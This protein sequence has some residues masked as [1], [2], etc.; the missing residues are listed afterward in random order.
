[1]TSKIDPGHISTDAIIDS[2]ID[3]ISLSES[4]FATPKMPSNQ[5][6]LRREAERTIEK[7]TI[8]EFPNVQSHHETNIHLLSPVHGIKLKEYYGWKQYS[9]SCKDLLIDFGESDLI[10]E[11]VNRPDTLREVITAFNRNQKLL[12]H[13]RIES[14]GR[15]SFGLVIFS[16]LK[17]F[18]TVEP[19]AEDFDNVI[20]AVNSDIER[21]C[22]QFPVN[23][24][25]SHSLIRRD[26]CHIV[27]VITNL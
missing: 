6:D 20:D 22:P 12:D 7:Y 24:D 9:Y 16:Y 19:G 10:I 25:I 2:I 11:C 14:G 8:D 5:S 13:I 27:G 17:Q 18:K 15:L 4:K 26:M 21:A 3:Y 23:L 1:M